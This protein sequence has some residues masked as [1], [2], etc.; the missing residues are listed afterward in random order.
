MSP[1]T[2]CIRTV[3]A[4]AVIALLLFA[5]LP[6]HA[7]ARA[8]GAE[9]ASVDDIIA[10]IERSPRGDEA[11]IDLRSDA[12]G[13]GTVMI[14]RAPLQPVAV[15]YT[16]VGNCLAGRPAMAPAALIEKIIGPM[17]GDKGL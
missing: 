14:V 12:A 9:I 17:P 11:V 5:A 1:W 13:E 8:C 10:M 15:I 16:F 2:I 7:A 6:V 4:G 3:I